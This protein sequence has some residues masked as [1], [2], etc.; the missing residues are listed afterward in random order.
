ML[1]LKYNKLFTSCNFK[2]NKFFK[3][4]FI[5]FQREGKGGREREKNI[6][7]QLPLTCSLLRTWPTT[8]ACALT[9][10]RSSNPVVHR[11][12]W[13]HPLSHT[14]QGSNKIILI[15][16]PFLDFTNLYTLGS[17]N[18]TKLLYSSKKIIDIPFYMR[19]VL[20]KNGLLVPLNSIMKTE[21]Q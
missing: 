6:N 18:F 2:Y 21:L 15:K 10:N 9:G 12:V 16:L 17:I 5:Y 3:D 14:S 1:S 8:Q 13:L 20:V 19:N 11:L 4:L 7:V